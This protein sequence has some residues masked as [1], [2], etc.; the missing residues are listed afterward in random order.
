MPAGSRT[1]HPAASVDLLHVLA[2]RALA[3][4]F[5]KSI[6]VLHASIR[7]NARQ[8]RQ[9]EDEDRAAWWDARDR[10][11]FS[12]SLSVVCFQRDIQPGGLTIALDCPS[13]NS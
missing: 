11:L 8:A 12:D 4:S 6:S 13:S 10:H 3:V 1:M 5:S 2:D 9:A 7:E